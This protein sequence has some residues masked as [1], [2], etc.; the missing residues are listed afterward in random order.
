MVSRADRVEERF[1]T[2]IQPI[3]DATQTVDSTVAWCLENKLLVNNPKCPKCNKSMRIFH[4]KNVL[5]KCYWECTDK[6]F[7]CNGKR[8]LRKF[9]HFE[10]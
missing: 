8:Y 2:D 6:Y 10:N 1:L 9:S 7:G 5:D 3:I 4:D